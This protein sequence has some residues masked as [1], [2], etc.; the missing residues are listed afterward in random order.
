MIFG[1]DDKTKCIPQ[2]SKWTGA[3]YSH[4]MS[5]FPSQLTAFMFIHF[6]NN[7]MLRKKNLIK[8]KLINQL[9]RLIICN[10]S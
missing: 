6:T 4:E 1:K 10:S 5:E 8:Y 9:Y 2:R 7:Y 3:K